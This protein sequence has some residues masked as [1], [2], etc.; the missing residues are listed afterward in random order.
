MSKKLV[1]K[2]ALGTAGAIL[3]TTVLPSLSFASQ[4]PSSSAIEANVIS[5]ANEVPVK[6][7]VDV[8]QPYV[9]TNKQDGT[10]YIDPTY[11]QNVQVPEAVIESIN[12]WFNVVN[13]DI[14]SGDAIVNSNL[15]VVYTGNNPSNVKPQVVKGG[16]NDFRTF[17]WGYELWMDHG[18]VQEVSNAMAIGASITKLVEIILKRVP[19]IPGKLLPILVEIST[20]IQG[21]GYVFLRTTDNGNG[22]YITF[23]YPVHPTRIDPQY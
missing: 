6:Q 4:S 14:K 9:H 2:I 10:L 8:L 21:T 11:K 16:V 18:T 15:E 3:A 7:Y 5:N 17:W 19:G 12:A 22:V 1:R 20:W 23:A 13:E